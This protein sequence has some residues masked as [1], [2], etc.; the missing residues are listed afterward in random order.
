MNPTPEELYGN[1]RY[2][3]IKALDVD[4]KNLVCEKMGHEIVARLIGPGAGNMLCSRCR[5]IIRPFTD[6][7]WEE[8]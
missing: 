6:Q 3:Q 8:M 1:E 4:P 7:E 2:E 5:F